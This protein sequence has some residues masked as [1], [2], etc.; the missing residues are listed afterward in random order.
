MRVDLGHT[1]ALNSAGGVA[2]SFG[3]GAYAEN[4]RLSAGG[5]QSV[6]IL[7][8]S[9]PILPS[10]TPVPPLPLAGDVHPGRVFLRLRGTCLRQE[11]RHE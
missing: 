4:F 11:G 2:L 7:Y 6:L 3:L 1:A 8:R 9:R 10:I 5:R